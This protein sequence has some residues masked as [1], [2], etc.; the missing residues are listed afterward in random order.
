MLILSAYIIIVSLTVMGEKRKKTK[1][2]EQF[3]ITIWT[4]M[5][6]SHLYFFVNDGVIIFYYRQGS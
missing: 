5:A 6:I 1:C 4:K 3:A 2:K